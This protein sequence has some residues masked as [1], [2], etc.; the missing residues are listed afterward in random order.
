MTIGQLKH[1]YS[2]TSFFALRNIILNDPEQSEEAMYYILRYRL[3]DA[4]R[5]I[6]NQYHLK[7]DYGDIM[8]DFQLYLRNGKAGNNVKPYQGIEGVLSI[9]YFQGWLKRTFKN[10]LFDRQTAE[11]K[12]ENMLRAY[13]KENYIE[14]EFDESQIRKTSFMIALMIQESTPEERFLFYRHLLHTMCKLDVIPSDRMCRAIGIKP[15]AYRTRDSRIYSKFTNIAVRLKRGD[16]PKLEQKYI[17]IANKI[18]DNFDDVS[19]IIKSLYVEN[20]QC[21]DAKLRIQEE[22][23]EDIRERRWKLAQE[24]KEQQ[25]K[26]L[27]QKTQETPK[28]KRPMATSVPVAQDNQES[29]EIRYSERGTNH[30]DPEIRYSERSGTRRIMNQESDLWF[31]KPIKPVFHRWTA[32]PEYAKYNLLTYYESDEKL[33]CDFIYLNPRKKALRYLR[34]SFTI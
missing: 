31:M 29:L 32:P 22:R 33:Y 6:Y 8:M 15:G 9:A 12:G 4:T 7:D 30:Y 24:L 27:E 2:D 11:T 14:E 1:K 34:E 16:T 5:A 10:F 19:S 23:E 28:V 21:M 3:M 13:A 20:L 17:D 25:T 26:Q 18:Y